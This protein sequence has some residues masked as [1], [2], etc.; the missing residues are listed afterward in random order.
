[1]KL[2]I[3]I[4]FDKELATAIKANVREIS[5]GTKNLQ[6]NLENSDKS[7]S[8]ENIPETK[9]KHA[10]PAAKRKARPKKTL[11]GT[12]LKVIKQNKDGISRKNLLEKT[13]F[14]KRQIIDCVYQL[15][16]MQKIEKTE[17]GLFKIL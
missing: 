7:A 2:N 3:T 4:E 12:V 6:T 5:E 15:K 11:R 17:D 1:M 13:G 9:P 10:K 14:S 8:T 16:A